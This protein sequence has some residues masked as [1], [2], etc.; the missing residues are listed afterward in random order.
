MVM[1]LL[2]K[3]LLDASVRSIAASTRT[4][5]EEPTRPMRPVSSGT[6][7]Q[8]SSILES[9]RGVQHH[10][11]ADFQIHDLVQRHHLFV[12]NG[13]DIDLG[14][15][16]FGRQ[17]AFP[18]GIAAEFLAHELLQQQLADRLQR[19]IGQQQF[20]APAAVF[21]VDAQLDQDGGIGG[22]GDGGEARIGL[23]AVEREMSPAP[24]ARRR[25]TC[26]AGSL[27]PCAAPACARWWCRDGPSMRMAA[28]PR[29][30]PRSTSTIE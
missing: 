3:A 22:P 24:A 16:Q 10:G 30:P 23:Q 19:R 18:D 11:L 2:F 25:R 6:P 14:G 15:P 8:R 9:G 27:P 13:V 26:P 7:R 29:R 12:E 21:H 5:T 1:S 20:G 17:M 4:A 28:E